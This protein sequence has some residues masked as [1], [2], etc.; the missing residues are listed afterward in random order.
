MFQ[1]Q[2]QLH[3]N[4]QCLV[5]ATTRIKLT[6]CYI[7]DVWF[8]VDDHCLEYEH[9]QSINM[10]KWITWILR[11]DFMDCEIR[12]FHGTDSIDLIKW[13]ERILWRFSSRT[14]LLLAAIF[15]LSVEF[16]FFF[17]SRKDFYQKHCDNRRW[18][19]MTITAEAWGR[20]W[21]N[22]FYSS[23]PVMLTAHFEEKNSTE[24][25][26]ILSVISNPTF[27]HNF[28]QRQQLC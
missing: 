3:R 24:V 7:V 20:L 28:Q 19:T 10:Y 23:F 26:F 13:R 17:W 9:K 14:I 12:T 1:L 5:R 18:A 16:F 25:H 22:P 27:T 2:L 11:N 8:I 6:D 21:L 4:V 15:E